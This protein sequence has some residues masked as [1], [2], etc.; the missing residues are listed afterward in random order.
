MSETPTNNDIFHAWTSR[1]IEAMHRGTS[2]L[3]SIQTFDW[4]IE[5]HEL[6]RAMKQKPEPMKGIR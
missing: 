3:R 2:W 6:I 4:Q 5:R 1:Q